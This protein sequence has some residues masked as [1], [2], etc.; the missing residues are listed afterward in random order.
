MALSMYD[1]CVPVCV[2]ALGGLAGVL[3][4]AAAHCE[5]RKIDPAALLTARLYPDMFTLTKQ[6]Q[7]ACDFG[8]WAVLRPAGME[9]ERI[10][11]TETDFAALRARV[12]STLAFLKAVKRE[13][14]DGSEERTVRFK[15]GER[16]FTFTGQS[17][18]L[19]FAL[20]NLFFHVTA[21]Y[22]ILRHNGVELGK[23]DFMGAIPGQ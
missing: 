11:D 15:A 18:L 21:A 23:R 13:Q 19:H 20:P 6:V 5:A 10:A 14:L 16:E 7:I 4:K 3:E 17:Y 9:V 8:R 22:A 12:A 1:V 2:Q